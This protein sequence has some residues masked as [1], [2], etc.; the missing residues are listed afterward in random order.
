MP[1][2]CPKR[3]LGDARRLIG[4]IAPD[5]IE[6]AGNGLYERAIFQQSGLR[7]QV[8]RQLCDIALQG[9]AQAAKYRE[10]DIA[11]SPLDRA[12]VRTVNV[13]TERQLLL[14]QADALSLHP[15]SPPQLSQDYFLVHR[16][17]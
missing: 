10:C 8:S 16:R 12:K 17:G 6:N 4:C 5:W 13:C 3:L 1:L 9:D 15:N 14:G 11:L 7:G 2:E